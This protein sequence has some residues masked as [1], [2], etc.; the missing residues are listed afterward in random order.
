MRQGLPNGVAVDDPAP[1]RGLDA[2][3]LAALQESPDTVLFCDDERSV[4]AR[5]FAARVQGIAA[6]YRQCG[7]QPGERVLLVTGSTVQS[8]A[9]LFAA[10]RAGLEPALAPCGLGPVELASYARAADAVALVGPTHYGTLALGD[11]YLSA[12]A[13][14]DTIRLVATLGP[15]AV[16]GAA[17]FGAA[18]LMENA[19]PF[20]A[21]AAVIVTFD[22]PANTPAPVAHR[23]AALFAAAL[24]L[25]DQA[26]INP[27][28][29]I[30][31][32]I[33]PATLAGLVAGP[34]AALIGASGL[35]LHGPFDSK[36]FLAAYDATLGAHLVA[37]ADMGATLRAAG[38]SDGDASLILLSR[39]ASPTG[40]VLPQA[41]DCARL[42]VDLY[43]F[44]EAAVLAR[45]RE[46][47]QVQIPSELS[48]GSLPGRLGV[49]L[50]RA[51]SESRTVAAGHG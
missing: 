22:G 29:P 8:L 48:D 26:Q 31:S 49:A 27:T 35:V 42:V 6:Q 51:R 36:S 3:L 34:F 5:D 47:G 15:Q 30:L 11:A 44:G 41:L 13:V 50:N 45:R 40:F 43:G 38:M 19:A 28:K 33:V 32:T 21:E 23:Q 9:A 16:D 14:S 20:G 4:S 24:A 46:G 37:P 1:T 17:D 2:L 39:F 25:V 7:L 12:A 10:L 18:A